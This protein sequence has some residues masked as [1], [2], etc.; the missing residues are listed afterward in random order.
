MPFSESMVPLLHH[1]SSVVHRAVTS[2][3]Y[4][5]AGFFLTLV[6]LS[7]PVAQ[8]QEVTLAAWNVST[9]TGGV[10]NFGISPLAASTA[11]P[12]VKVTP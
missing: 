11:D 1:A 5:A 9:Q 12:N 6:G 4:A 8:G 3:R 10:N 7:L 2:V